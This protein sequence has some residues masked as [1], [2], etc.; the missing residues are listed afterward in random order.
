MVELH[1][2]KENKTQKLLKRFHFE[3]TKRKV[4]I[5]I[6]LRHQGNVN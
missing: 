6:Q 2:A 1:F 5:E 3:A 4:S